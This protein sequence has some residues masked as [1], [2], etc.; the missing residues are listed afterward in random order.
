[1]FVKRRQSGHRA[2]ALTA[3]ATGFLAIGLAFAGLGDALRHQHEGLTSQTEDCVVDHDRHESIEHLTPVD[4]PHVEGEGERHQHE[5]LGCQ[6]HRVRVLFT[7]TAERVPLPVVEAVV[8]M[9][10]VQ[11]SERATC[12]RAPRGPPRNRTA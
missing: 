9:P 12:H 5:C 10:V 2:R 6:G 11:R 3:L 7:A 8:R 4:E 1:M